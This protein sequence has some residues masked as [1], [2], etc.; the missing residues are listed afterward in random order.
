MHVGPVDQVRPVDGLARGG[1]GGLPAPL[2]CQCAEHRGLGGA[3]A[4]GAGRVGFAGTVKE[5][6]E[7]P[8]TAFGELGGARVLGV[9]DEVAMQVGGDHLDRFG[10][11]ERGHEGRQ[12]FRRVPVENHLRLEQ[13][14]RRPWLAAVLGKATVDRRLREVPLSQV[15]VESNVSPIVGLLVLCHCDLPNL[16]CRAA[17]DSRAHPAGSPADER[18]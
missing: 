7:H 5:T 4:R 17:C 3:G 8:D 10:L 14:D 11:H 13:R 18:A 15:H 1:A 2:H 6:V 9:V 16:A 12:V